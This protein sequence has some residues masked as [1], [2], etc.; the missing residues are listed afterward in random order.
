MIVVIWGWIVLWYVM[1]MVNVNK[2]SVVVIVDG[3]DLSVR[4]LVV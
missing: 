3:E 1:V 4:L 2:E